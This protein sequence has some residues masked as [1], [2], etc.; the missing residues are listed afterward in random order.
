M[1]GKQAKIL[2]KQEINQVLYFLNNRRYALRDQVMFL[3]SFKAGLRAK[4]ISHLT[5]GM[6]TDA[7]GNIGN[8]LELTDKAS[9]GKSGRTIPL[10]KQLKEALV[11]LYHS[12]EMLPTYDQYIIFSERGTKMMPCN[13]SHWFRK[14]Y[15]RLRFEGCSCHSGRRTFVTNGAK[16]IIQAGGSLKDIQELVGHTSLAVTQ[17]YIVGDVEAKRKFIELI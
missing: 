7:S 6:V 4:E 17:R 13:V 5:W 1:A 2:S 9:K 16:L 11:N 8:Y 14:I 15:K 12:Y 3:L 10:H